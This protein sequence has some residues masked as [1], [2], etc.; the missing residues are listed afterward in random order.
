M[1]FVHKN[2]IVSL[3]VCRCVCRVTKG[4]FRAP[5]SDCDMLIRDTWMHFSV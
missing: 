3:R 4:R 1:N 2:T 5:M